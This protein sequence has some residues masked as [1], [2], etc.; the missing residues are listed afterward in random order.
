MAP[1]ECNYEIHDKEMLAIIR[2]LSQWRAELQGTGSRIQIYT[3]HKALEYFMTTKQLTSRQARWA[4]ILSQ[5]FFTI[6]YRPGRQNAQADALTRREQDV[7]PQDE[8]NA[9]H[10]TRALL[11]LDQ[12]DPAILA[13]LPNNEELPNKLANSDV[14]AIEAEE[15]HEPIGLID[16]IIT[17]NRTATS[18]NAL[19]AQ[20]EAGDGDL[21]LE[22]GLLLYQDRLVV[23]DTDQLRTNLIKEAHEQVS[24]AHPGRTKTIRLL[25]DRYYWKGLAASV[26]QYI[27][28]CHACKRACAPRDRTPGWLHPLPIPERPWQHITIDFQSLSKD[29]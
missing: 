14:L 1:A 2:S 24:T 15:L 11:Q 16:Q 13:G 7:E 10:R 28:N 5:F 22:D 9:Q 21:K 8:L 23:P 25:A 18:L 6:M 4:E 17:A 3:D 19:R 26:A 29:S 12:L 27:R 20:A